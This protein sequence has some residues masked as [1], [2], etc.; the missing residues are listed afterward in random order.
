MHGT[1]GRFDLLELVRAEQWTPGLHFVFETELEHMR[2]AASELNSFLA[3]YSTL[4]DSQDRGEWLE[5][6][7][8]LEAAQIHVRHGAQG[9][10]SIYVALRLDRE[11]GPMIQ[12]EILLGLYGL[13]HWKIVLHWVRM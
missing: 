8:G 4:A 3:R 7:D 6:L 5:F 12:G 1:N 9:G 10:P 11:A 13:K 2:N